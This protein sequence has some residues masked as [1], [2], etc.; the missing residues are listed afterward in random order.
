MRSQIRDTFA[1]AEPD[2]FWDRIIF[3]TAVQE[4]IYL[5]LGCLTASVRRQ[6]GDLRS[7]VERAFFFEQPIAAPGP[8]KKVF[9]DRQALTE[10]GRFD[11]STRRFRFETRPEGALGTKITVRGELWVEPAPDGQVVRCCDLDASVNLFGV[12]GLAERFVKKSNEDIYA[13]RTAIVRR[14]IQEHGL[15]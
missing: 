7:G 13:Q 9:G 2:T 6:T 3:N 5:E 1:I 12:G 15:R 8:L 4:Q 11:P 10:V 14:I